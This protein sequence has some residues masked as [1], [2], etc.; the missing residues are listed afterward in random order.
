M[1]SLTDRIARPVPSPQAQHLAR[2]AQQLARD[3]R[4]AARSRTCA[5]AWPTNADHPGRIR[6]G[7][8]ETAPGPPDGA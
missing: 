1:R 8:G 3:P 5:L 6:V 7:E 4:L 2:R